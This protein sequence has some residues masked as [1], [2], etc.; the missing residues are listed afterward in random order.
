MTPSQI[1]WKYL[2]RDPKSS[3]R[4][5]SIKGRRIKARTLYGLSVEG[6]EPA[7]P[8]EMIAE[9]YN[10]PV[11]AVKEA[12]AYCESNPPELPQDYKFDEMIMEAAGMNEPG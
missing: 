8:V 12:I 2:E 10:I 7:W 1:Q 3:Y 6:D 4:Q 5:L 9:Q 11:E